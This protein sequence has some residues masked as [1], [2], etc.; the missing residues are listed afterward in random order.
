MPPEME[1]TEITCPDCGKLIA[2]PGE[3]A[4][5]QRCQCAELKRRQ[6][7]EREEVPRSSK[8]CYVCGTNLEGHKRLKDH[9]GRYWCPECAA[10]DARL[11]KRED[12]L[13]CPD[14]SRV[15]PDHKLVYFQT[16]RV[17]QTCYK[18]R[19]RVLERKIAKYGA[20]KSYKSEEINKLK[21]MAIIAIGL[22]VIA[23]VFQMMR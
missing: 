22:I 17:C 4:D 2:P 3:V 16:E 23:T 10:A 9:L 18:E 19:E 12:E 11:K 6:A 20:E 15:F 8:S 5:S 14:C 21:W 1:T 7:E 13:R